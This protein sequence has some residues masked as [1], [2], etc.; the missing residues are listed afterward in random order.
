M[1]STH[2]KIAVRT[3][4]RGWLRGH[5]DPHRLRQHS[6]VQW[7]SLEGLM[8]ELPASEVK[9]VFFLASFDDVAQLEMLRTAAVRPRRPGL[10]VRVDYADG[11]SFH[12]ILG[13]RLTELDGTGLFLLPATVSAPFQRV[14]IPREAMAEAA[15]LGVVGHGRRRAT[16]GGQQIGL[17]PAAPISEPLSGSASDVR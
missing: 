2:K 16:P 6:R 5:L 14:Y 15:V 3:R 7:L 9:G 17:F 10:W 1:P 4:E 8:T 11:E 12:G 13:N